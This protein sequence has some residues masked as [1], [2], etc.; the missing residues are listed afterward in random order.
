MLLAA[1]AKVLVCPAMN[2]C[3]FQHPA[4]MENLQMLKQRGIHI[5]EPSE[6]ELA[7]GTEGPGRL[8]EPEEIAEEAEFLLT[9]QD[10]AGI[11][12]LIT[13]GA[14]LEPIDPVRYITNR[15]SGKMGYAL[16]RAAAMRGAEV[17]LVSGPTHLNA[18][19]RVRCLAVNTTEEMR[20]AVLE[21]SRDSDVVIKAAAVLDYRPRER[22]RQKIKKGNQNLTLELQPNPDILAELG[23]AR[24]ERRSVLVGFAAETTDLLAHA[25]EKLEKKNLDLIVANDVTRTDAGFDSDTNLVKIL[26]RDGTVEDLPL[27]TKLA[28]AHQVLDRVKG[29]WE[30]GSRERSQ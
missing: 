4:V 13:A 20:Q 22:S 10:L 18:P 29:L 27:M 6:G 24:G 21:R 14:T 25:K 23:R 17:T 12:F 5:L 7:C 9:E 3:M 2:T 30:R 11:R 19:P 28:V 16:A 15:S 26:Y 8:P 1:T